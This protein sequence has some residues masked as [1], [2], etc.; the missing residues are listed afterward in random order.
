MHTHSID[1]Q[2]Y[3]TGQIIVSM[4]Q[5]TDPKFQRSVIFIC[6]HDQ[7][8]AMGIYLNKLIDGLQWGQLMGQL[9][10]TGSEA[11]LTQPPIHF[12]GPMEP[13]RGFVIHTNEYQSENTVEISTSYSLTATLEILKAINAGKGPTNYILA[14]GYAGWGPGQLD[15]EIQTSAW[16]SI[17]PTDEILFKY[18]AEEKWSHAL[19]FLGIT[20]DMVSTEIGH[21]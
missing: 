21:A 18:S 16:V 12:G 7:N 15:T 14:L 2:K 3:L 20:I 11:L 13:G 19:D 8:G 6:G 17:E 5:M 10:I 4:P 9:G 1:V